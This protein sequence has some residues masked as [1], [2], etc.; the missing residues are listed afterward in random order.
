MNANDS[1]MSAEAVPRQRAQHVLA[2]VV[3]A[4]SLCW[5]AFL[6]RYPLMYPDSIGYIGDGRAIAAAR[7]RRHRAC[8]AAVE[9]RQP[10]RLRILQ[11]PAAHTNH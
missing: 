3:A 6:N 4:I 9:N 5:P 10:L 7:L 1:I 8:R 2:V 11:I